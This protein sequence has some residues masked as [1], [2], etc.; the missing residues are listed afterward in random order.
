MFVMKRILLRILIVS[1][2]AIPFSIG[3]ITA[4]GSSAADNS[5]FAT[6]TGAV[7][8]DDFKVTRNGDVL[9]CSSLISGLPC[10]GAHGYK[11]I[12]QIVPKGKVYLGFRLVSGLHGCTT[13]EVYWKD[14]PRQPD[15]H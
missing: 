9:L 6:A 5:H 1:G 4:R 7:R 15:Q 8:I 10:Y 13:Y 2:Y 12:R 11:P 14:K 3:L